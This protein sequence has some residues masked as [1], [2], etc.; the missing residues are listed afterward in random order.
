MDTKRGVAISIF[1]IKVMISIII[2][3]IKRSMRRA[4][5]DKIVN[6]GSEKT[7]YLRHIMACINS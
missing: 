7:D 5:E 3:N 1:S 2:A 4:G 6:G